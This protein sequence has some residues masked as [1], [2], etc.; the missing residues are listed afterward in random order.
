MTRVEIP[1]TALLAGASG[2]VGG[3]CLRAL[4]ASPLYD[5]VLVVTRRD[6]GDQ[7]AH[8]KIQQIVVDFAE[9][10]SHAP[11]LAAQHA[12]C[13]LGTTIK[14]AG[15]R[16]R[17]REV[18][19]TYPYDLA[20]LTLA[21]GAGHFSI[22]SAIGASTRSRFYYSRVKG[23][24]EVALRRMGWPSLAILRPSVIAGKRAESRPF[25]QVGVRVLAFGPRTWRP[26]RAAT[27]AEAMVAVA[28]RE[29]PGVTI[30]ESRDIPH[31]AA[32][33]ATDDGES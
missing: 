14:K 17:F 1:K 12:F 24:L 30:V 9:L 31:W 16:D 20:R 13:A 2:L 6:L 21:R 5:R 7:V 11:R 25:E 22:V 8:P 33:F 26:V 18:D 15:T 28:R 23:E 10:A 29:P 3:E 27:I 19:F 32:R 4:T